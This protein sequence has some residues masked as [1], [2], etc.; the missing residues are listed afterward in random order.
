[1]ML[2]SLRKLSVTSVICPH[3]YCDSLD[4]DDNEEAGSALGD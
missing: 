1:M 3:E 4:C 2:G